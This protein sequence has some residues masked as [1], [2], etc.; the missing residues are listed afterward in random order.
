[1]IAVKPMPESGGGKKHQSFSAP[2]I[3][4]LRR[5]TLNP[6]TLLFVAWCVI[7]VLGCSP[8]QDLP[9]PR[10]IEDT[11]EEPSGICF[12]KQTGT[13]FVVSDEG[14]IFEIDK[15]GKILRR[16]YLGGDLEDVCPGPDANTLLV[17]V[18][19]EDKLLVVDWRNLV[20]IQEILIDSWADG[21][22][23]L[24]EDDDHG[25]EGLIY[26]RGTV[27]VT[28]QSYIIVDSTSG[29]KSD[30]SA[31]LTIAPPKCHDCDA[32]IVFVDYQ[33]YPDLAAVSAPSDSSNLF[34]ISDEEDLLLE[35]NPVAGVIVEE[36]K[37]FGEEQEG[38]AF[39]DEGNL[40]IAQ[41]SGGILKINFEL[42]KRYYRRNK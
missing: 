41:D 34:L 29:H 33:Q 10:L 8:S 40:Y 15:L 42:F 21:R 14:F 26:Y 13:L 2:G 25:I 36:Y 6:K 7:R 3:I 39:D 30:S 23:I 22:L 38:L 19:R 5:K 32:E 35:Y 28:N 16:S 27:L 11:I 1:M 12:L 24:E 9:Q 17:A 18:E 31:L 4:Y 20:S 37:L